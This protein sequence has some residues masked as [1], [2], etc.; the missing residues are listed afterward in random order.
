MISVISSGVS[1]QPPASPFLY[2][3]IEARFKKR[4]MVLNMPAA[5]VFFS[6]LG[7]IDE[8]F[9]IV[10]IAE[11]EICLIE[12]LIFFYV[13][14]QPAD[15]RCCYSRFHTRHEREEKPLLQDA[16]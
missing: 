1:M 3:G 8:N 13:P 7:I 16:P 5:E 6:L 14:Q 2:N 10:V 4:D 11:F 15:N 9:I 12:N